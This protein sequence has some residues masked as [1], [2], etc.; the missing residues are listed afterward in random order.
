MHVWY[1]YRRSFRVSG[2]RGGKRGRYFLCD[3]E[4]AG[5]PT[6]SKETQDPIVYREH[7]G[8]RM[9]FPE[10][11]IRFDVKEL[12][13]ALRSI[14]ESPGIEAP[15]RSPPSGC[16]GVEVYECRKLVPCQWFRD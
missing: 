6:W 3:E 11:V 16:G 10:M 9:E 1:Q 14:Q 4:E 5:A 12:K 15:L 2:M 7:P 13:F 8:G